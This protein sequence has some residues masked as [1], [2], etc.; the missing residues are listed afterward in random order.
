LAVV[1]Q[2]VFIQVVIL[3]LQDHQAVTLYFPLLHLL[4][5]AEEVDMQ[6]RLMESTVVLVVVELVRHR[7]LEPLALE[8]LLA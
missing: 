5:A 3:G 7:L 6:Q 4:V 2:V 8:I 1:A